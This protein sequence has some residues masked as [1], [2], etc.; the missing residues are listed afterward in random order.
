ME[1]GLM[2][3]QSTYGDKKEDMDKDIRDAHTKQ[4]GKCKKM[5]ATASQ[6]TAEDVITLHYVTLHWIYFD[7]LTQ[8]NGEVYVQ[9][10]YTVTLRPKMKT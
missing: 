6:I 1:Q 7:N 4:K 10:N 3:E 9:T 2:E 5:V 8:R